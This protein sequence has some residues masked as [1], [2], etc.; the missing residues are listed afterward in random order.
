MQRAN[1]TRACFEV[2]SYGLQGGILAANASK[3]RPGRVLSRA[4]FPLRGPSETF[5]I[6]EGERSAEGIEAD[7]QTLLWRFLSI[8]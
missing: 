7:R 6:V 3:T 4:G 1:S 5:G 8:L 2:G